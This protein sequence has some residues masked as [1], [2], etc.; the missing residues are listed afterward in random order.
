MKI[1]SVTMPEAYRQDDYGYDDPEEWE[2][3]VRGGKADIVVICD[4]PPKS[5]VKAGYPMSADSLVFFSQ[6]A[7]PAGF[8]KGDISWV[9]LCPPM[10]DKIKTSNSKKWKHVEPYSEK[11]VQAALS[12]EP[13]MI[14]T[15]GEF[16]SRIALGSPIKITKAR[17]MV[18]DSN[19]FELPFFPMFSPG[20][21]QR[22]PENEPAFVAD[23]NAVMKLREAGFHSEDVERLEANYS[24]ELDL[25]DEMMAQ[26]KKVISVDTETTGLLWRDPKVH[27]LTVQIS[28]RPGLS[29]VFPID[30]E[31]CEKWFPEFSEERRLQLVAKLK[32]ILE[33]PS[34]RKIGHNIKYDHHLLRKSDILVKGW[35]HDTQLMAFC[36]DENMLRKDLAE[37]TRVWVPDMAGYSDEF[38]RHVDKSRMIDVPPYTEYNE[39]GTVKVYGMLEYAGGDPDATF[40][41]ARVLQALLRQ[42]A[43]QMNIYRRIQIPA[44]MVFANSVERFGMGV[45]I[46][47]LREL[48][49]DLRAYSSGK[50]REMIRRVPAKVRRKHLEAGLKF[51]RTEFVKDI[52]FSKEGFNLTPKMWTDGTKDLPMSERVPS[53][54][55][56][57]LTY[58]V[59]DSRPN[60]A[61]F[62]TD[63]IHLS[64]ARKMI[65]TYVGSYEKQTGFHKYIAPDGN[66]Y[67]SY[68]LHRTNTGRTASNDP[69]GQNMPVRSPEGAPNWAKQHQGI[70]QARPGYKWVACDKSQVELRLV[71]WTSNDPTMLE[72]Y[73]NNGDIH[74]TT[75]RETVLGWTEERWLAQSPADIKLNR[76]KAK[77]VN[78]GLIY[79]MSAEGF[80]V[81]AKTDY[82]IDITLDEARAL[83]D[84]FFRNFDTLESWHATMKEFAHK[85][86]YVRALHGA[87]R[88]LPVIYSNDRAIV[89][90]AERQAINAPIQRLASDLGLIAM[91]RFASQM[92]ADVFRLIGFIHDKLVLECR[93]EY[94]ELGAAHLK[95]VME[96]DPLEKW[97]GVTSPI[98]LL[99]DAEVSTDRSAGNMVER[100]DIQAIKPE[101][102]DDDEES[103]IE[104]FMAGEEVHV[105]I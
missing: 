98:P 16:A 50:Y 93:D 66:I 89:A 29:W 53:T 18:Q 57:H 74:T 49:E 97:F 83:R 95:W 90:M 6:R 77:A 72:V 76:F 5:A 1:T 20:F 71:A 73:K 60:V 48:E 52:L 28:P 99:G 84:R 31:Y 14:I 51:S 105:S 12:L 63:L 27:V 23:L 42:D 56:D 25:T 78:F 44:I 43:R 65:S 59:S 13:K 4:P 69:N 9:Q 68:M 62:C 15:M 30:A 70:F 82:G 81:Y 103:A 3:I 36:V 101:W 75:A 41:N 91:I 38:D 32:R 46:A 85:Y 2:P 47:K 19:R 10:P 17:G 40:R 64:A 34:V 58:F 7:L 94:E 33:E 37:C 87:V 26:I 86:G 54:S 22:L 8:K 11:V 100:P 67:P 45:D 21:V 61:A 35:L 39:D 96:T 24:W 79:G 80:Q 88:H 92:P 55:K 104:R 102:W